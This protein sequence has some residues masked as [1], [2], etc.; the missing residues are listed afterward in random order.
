MKVKSNIRLYNNCR[1]KNIFELLVK[2]NCWNVLLRWS[3]CSNHLYCFLSTDK[4]VCVHK[5]VCNVWDNYTKHFSTASNILPIDHCMILNLSLTSQLHYTCVFNFYL[6]ATIY[7]V[8]TL[9]TLN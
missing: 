6:G 5:I 4:N 1:I 9:K 2:D 7:L 8:L 3:E